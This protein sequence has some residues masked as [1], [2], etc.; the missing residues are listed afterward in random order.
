MTQSP[1]EALA[2][3]RAERY[4]PRPTGGSTVAGV[5]GAVIAS[6]A[7]IIAARF[8]AWPLADH[9]I[10]AVL[11]GAAG[12]ALGVVGYK[13][14]ARRHHKARRTELARIESE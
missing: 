4:A 10:V 13:R 8:Y 14:A 11:I 9:A 12:F 3:K 2:T 7:A 1:Q 5:C 6:L